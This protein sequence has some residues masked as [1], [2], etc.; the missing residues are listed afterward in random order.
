MTF[1]IKKLDSEDLALA[2]QLFLFFQIDDGVVNPT[3]ASDEYLNNLL[4]RDDFHV[5]VAIENEMV[6][7]GLTAYELAMCKE[8]TTE[9]FLYEIGVE[10]LHRKKGVA[11]A[12]VEFLK[13]ISR[14]KGITYMFVG[15]EADNTP[16]IRLYETTGGKCEDIA[17]FVYE[18]D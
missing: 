12:L 9:I 8:E 10:P 2:K 6:I 11:R 14:V 7:G 18:Y 1:S 13:E 4:S 3:A 15:T 17:W 16:A 5:I